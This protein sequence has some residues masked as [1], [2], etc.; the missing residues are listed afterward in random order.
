MMVKF[1]WQ[2]EKLASAS[3]TKIQFWT[4]PTEEFLVDLTYANGADF[5]DLRVWLEDQQVGKI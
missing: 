4:E 1:V 5:L 3:F 2:E